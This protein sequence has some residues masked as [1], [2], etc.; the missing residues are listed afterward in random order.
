LVGQSVTKKK[1]TKKT[2][3]KREGRN[4]FLNPHTKNGGA[5]VVLETKWEKDGHKRVFC[6]SK[7]RLGIFFFSVNI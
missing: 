3:V 6:C 7:K 4:T 5:L 2:K 1:R